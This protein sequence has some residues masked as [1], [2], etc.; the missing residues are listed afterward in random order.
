MPPSLEQGTVWLVTADH[1]NCDEMLTQTGAILTQH[2]LNRVP[3]VVSG[4]DFEGRNDLIEAGDF[5]LSD[6][7]PTVLALLGLPQPQEMTGQSIV[8]NVTVE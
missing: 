6:I 7:A 2:S 4:R 5:G 3:F 8:K 1:G